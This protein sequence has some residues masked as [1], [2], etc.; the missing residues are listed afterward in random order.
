[1]KYQRESE[2]NVM[3]NRKIELSAASVVLML[4]VIF[5]HVAAECV[6]LFDRGSVHYTVAVSLHR[7]SSFAVQGFI[8]LSGVKLFLSRRDLSLGRFYL[9][10][11]R[12]VVLPYIAAFSLFFVYFILTDRITPSADYFFGELI[13][14]GLVGHFYFVAVICQFYLLIPLWR[15]IVKKASPVFALTVSLG[16]MIIFNSSMPEMLKLIFGVDFRYNARLFTT[17]IFYFLAGAF[18]GASYDRFAA[19]LSRHRRGIYALLAVVGLADCVNIWL[20]GTRRAYPSWAENLHVLYCISAILALMCAALRITAKESRLS[21][22]A[23][24]VDRASYNV[25][26]IHPLFIFLTESVL[27]RC[28]IT[29][30]S[31]RFAAKF[32]VTYICSIGICLLIEIVKGKTRKRGG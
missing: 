12:R 32:A 29:S 8:F 9:G 13:S 10:R 27:Y 18:A 23:A 25:Y 17:Y 1:M 30:L 3:K 28:G 24:Y 31:A 15:M 11:L 7:L 5:I 21:S 20:I 26:L 6:S 2:K 22:A 14:G 16:L 19:E 4:L